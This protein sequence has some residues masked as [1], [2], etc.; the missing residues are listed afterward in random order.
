MPGFLVRAE[1]VNDPIA[2][3]LLAVSAFGLAVMA[4]TMGSRL[5]SVPDTVVVHIDAA[6]TPDRWG[7][8]TTLWRLPLMA[9]MV[10]LMNLVGAWFLAR[11]DAFA[12]RFLVATALGVQIIAWVA[13]SRYLW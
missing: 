2:L 5:G 1:L 9:A 4:A 11:R 8:N 3:G 12:G 10:T 6:G 13:V 7:P